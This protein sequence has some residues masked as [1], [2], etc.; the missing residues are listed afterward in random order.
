MDPAAAARATTARALWVERPGVMAVRE[1][2]LPA[3]GDEDVLVRTRCSGVSRGTER[4]VLAGRVP[5]SQRGRMRAPFQQGDLPGPVSHGYLAVGVVEQGPAGHL[6]RTVF[7]LHPHHD[8]FVVP[9]AAARL[10]PDGVPARRAVLAGTVETAV[11]V[12][13]DAGVRLGDR[14][15]VVGAGMVGACVARLAAQVPGCTVDLVDPQPA[16]AA[17]AAALHVAHRYPDDLSGVTGRHDVVVHTSATAV[18]LALALRLAPDDGEVVEASWF[19]DEAPV[20]PLGED[21]HARRV[22][23][24]PSQVGAVATSRRGR[25]TTRE[26]LDLALRLLAD[27]AFDHVLGE[28]VPFERAPDLLPDLLAGG[29]GGSGLCPVITYGA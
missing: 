11:N 5:A 23:I 6:G 9:A 10:V 18:G 2:P 22:S 16:R 27:P 13:W 21:V 19:G 29:R 28:D 24:R 25:R 12:L 3:V 4:L 7:V 20:V 15:A 1:Q 17:L 14:V 26:R 8:R